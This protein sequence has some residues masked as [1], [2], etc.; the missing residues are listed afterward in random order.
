MRASRVRARAARDPAGPGAAGPGAAETAARSAALLRS[1][2]TPARVFALLASEPR[3]GGAVA[4]IA[5]RLSQGVPVAAAIARVD[6]PEW[7]LMAAVWL[8]AEES[9]APLAPA[10]DR[11]GAA[12]RALE[13][14]RERRSVL[15]S[16]PRA[17]VRLV[18]ALP[19]LALLLGWLLGFDPLPVLLSPLGF[20][21]LAVG[22]ALLAAGVLWARALQRRV[23]RADRV[24]GL[25]C[26]L[27]AVALGGG[28]P[29]A[30]ACRRAADCADRVGAEWV[31]FDAFLRSG[32]LASAIGTAERT[33]TP[34]GPLLL[35]EAAGARS[36]ARAELEGAAERL[37]VRVLVP[38]GLCA[39][40]SFIVLGVV[41][42]LVSMLGAG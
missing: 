29:P 34:L 20:A 18:S 41:P 4:G 13:Q 32:P 39:L 14:L 21:L 37:G 36:R 24:A 6:A 19:P 3:A 40:P 7:R 1:G 8:L 26:E 33:G 42:V 22:G 17:T 2:M 27:V 11:I 23:E 15:L 30:A 31:S 35:E 12:L 9:G 10:L 25:E 16:G 28:A 38:L 5:E